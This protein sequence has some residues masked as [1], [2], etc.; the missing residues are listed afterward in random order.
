MQ[1]WKYPSSSG[2]GEYTTMLDDSGL[3]RCDCKGYLI[4]REGQPRKCR[5]IDDVIKR[6]QLTTEI[7]GDYIYS[8][9]EGSPTLFQQ[10]PLNHAER[11]SKAHDDGYVEPMLAS[12]MT[13]GETIEQYRDNHTAEIKYDGVRVIL[14]VGKQTATSWSRPRPGQGSIGLVRKLPQHVELAAVRLLP[15]ATY[16]GE[17]IAGDAEKSYDVSRLDKQHNQVLVLFDIL[18]FEG[19]DLTGLPIEARKELLGMAVPFQGQAIRLAESVPPTAEAVKKLWDAG[20]EGVILKRAGSLYKPGWRSPDWRKIKL[21]C[22]TTGTV[23]GFEAA[24]MG[25]FS[26]VC[27]LSDEGVETTVKTK[28][29]Y[30]LREFAANSQAYIGKRLVFKHYGLTPDKKYRGPIIWD[31]WAGEGE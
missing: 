26:K 17:L 3:L 15:A 16:D 8:V 30:W 13:K 18:K 29:N 20:A 7:R 19:R 21:E 4:K 12:A 24:K 2:P 22:Y 10:E 14:A 5:H 6:S 27:L 11:F 31:H 9:T 25:P 28:D 1:T 23:T